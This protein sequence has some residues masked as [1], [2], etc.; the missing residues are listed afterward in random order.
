MT[1]PPLPAAGPS[2]FFFI[3]PPKAVSRPVASNIC[4]TI[5]PHAADV[6]KV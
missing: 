1:L 3:L 5:N 4:G 6:E 2:S